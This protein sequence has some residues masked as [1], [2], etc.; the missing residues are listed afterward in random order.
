MAEMRR[1][2]DASVLDNLNLDQLRLNEPTTS[3]VNQLGTLDPIQSPIDQGII[4]VGEF[5][6][7][8]RPLTQ[9]EFDRQRNFLVRDARDFCK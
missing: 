8:D 4:P 1:G 6:V 7:K 3:N 5:D 9:E 2:T